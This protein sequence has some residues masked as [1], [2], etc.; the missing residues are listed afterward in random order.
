MVYCLCSL[1]DTHISRSGC[2][3]AQSKM[4]EIRQDETGRI[5]GWNIAF[6]K[7]CEF[8]LYLG[9]RLLYKN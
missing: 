6:E 1:T 2:K 3:H 7:P 9:V 4:V 5:A 8:V